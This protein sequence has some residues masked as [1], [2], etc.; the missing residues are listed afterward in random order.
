MNLQTL[1]KLFTNLFA[2]IG[3]MGLLATVV[4]LVEMKFAPKDNGTWLYYTSTLGEMMIN[5]LFAFIFCLVLV[6]VVNGSKK[7]FKLLNHS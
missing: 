3:G 2:V 5:Y 6:M 4:T 7:L 1:K